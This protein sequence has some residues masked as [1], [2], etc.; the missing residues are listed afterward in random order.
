MCIL[1]Y[2]NNPVVNFKVGKNNN[3][4]IYMEAKSQ[5]EDPK[6]KLET[7]SLC[8]TLPSIATR[9]ILPLNSLFSWVIKVK[10]PDGNPF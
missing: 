7:L 4:A 9:I 8:S 6:G 10:F 5:I 1:L 2:N 3:V